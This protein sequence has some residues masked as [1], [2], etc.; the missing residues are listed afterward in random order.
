MPASSPRNELAHETSPYL[1]Q[2]QFNPVH[3]KAWGEAA[4]EEAARL[5]K[6]VIVSIGYSACHWCHVMEHETFEDVEAAAFMNEHFVCVKVDREER[7]DVDQVY[8]DAVQLMTQRGGWPLNCVAMPDGRP[9]WG[10]TY[11]PKA[12]WLK[13]LEGLVAVWQEEPETV[14]G[15]AD[16]LSQAVQALHEGPFIETAAATSDVDEAMEALMRQ[17]QATWDLNHGGR[18]GAPKFPLPAQASFLLRWSQQPGAPLNKEARSH[19]LRTLEGIEQGGIHDHVGGGFARYSVDGAWHVPHFEKMLY[20]NGQMLVA[21]A[22]AHQVEARATWVRAMEG[23]VDWILRE[24]DSASGGFHAAMDADSDGSEGAYYVWRDEDLVEALP[25]RGMREAVVRAFDV[26]GTSHWENGLNVLQRTS[27]E[28]PDEAVQDALQRMS[29]WRDS[30]ASGRNK[31]GLDDKVI[32]GWTALATKGL[33][34]AGRVLGRDEWVARAEAAGAFLLGAARVPG[35]EDLLRR[36]WHA[37]GGPAWEGYAEDY[38]YAI[39]ALLELHQTT[40]DPR[41]RDEARALMATA[42]DRFWDDEAGTFWF[43]ARG[44]ETAFAR[45]Q[46]VEDSVMPSANAVLAKSLWRLGWGCDIP[47]WRRMAQGLVERRLKAT[48]HL[49]HA[50]VWAEAWQDMQEPYA[51]VAIAGASREA[52]TEALADW[53]KAGRPGCWVDGVWPASVNTPAWMDS[54][55]PHDDGST[56]WYVCV[57]GTCAPPCSTAEEAWRQA[58]SWRTPPPTDD[59][60]A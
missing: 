42:L 48:Q 18:L 16:R 22:D 20:D 41:W 17:W 58:S 4:F 60:Q 2:H 19:A 6:P 31:P 30:P 51:T 49:D 23:T 50:T 43:V 25:E 38:A 57:E 24:M 56:R 13:A 46:S 28:G 55:T 32:T 40:L 7:P 36:T 3:W 33:A 14:R 44:Q 1:R 52:V 27:R 15:Y 45:H 39:D 9:I 37:K 8:M 11:F 59:S 10:G 47:A 34:R 53:H 26:D 29:D 5:N 12:Q 21:L 54:K 35:Q